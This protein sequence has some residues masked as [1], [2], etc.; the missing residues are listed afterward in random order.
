MEN[1][2]DV[3]TFNQFE[4]VIKGLPEEKQQ[5]I[6]KFT[7]SMQGVMPVPNPL[8]EKLTTEH[9]AMLLENSNKE[10]ERYYQGNKLNKILTTIIVVS[11]L[12]IFTTLVIVFRHH[13]SDI[14]EL[15]KYLLTAILSCLGGYGLGYKNGREQE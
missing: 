1:K 3:A 11:V 15:L 5:E 14:S 12:L 7:L 9:I 4:E 6:K 8:V 13:V 10:S 2:K